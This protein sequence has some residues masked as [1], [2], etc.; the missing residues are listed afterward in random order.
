MTRVLC[1]CGECKYNKNNICKAKEVKIRSWKINTVNYGMK[2]MEEC[3][4]Y[5][6]SDEFKEIQKILNRTPKESE[7]R[8]E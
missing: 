5:E 7:E 3:I 6:L 8:E 2:R 4:T 1:A